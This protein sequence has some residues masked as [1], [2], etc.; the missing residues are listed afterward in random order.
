MFLRLIFHF[1]DFQFKVCRIK[2]FEE[3]KY[4]GEQKSDKEK[5]LQINV[6][7][8]SRIVSQIQICHFPIIWGSCQLQ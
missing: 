7:P 3:K 6:F 5:F 8:S 2:N 4:S 1:F